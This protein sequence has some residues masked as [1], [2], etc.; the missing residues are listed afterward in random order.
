MTN[1]DSLDVYG[2]MAKNLDAFQDYLT[3]KKF[4]WRGWLYWENDQ[5]G[6]FYI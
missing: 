1:T 6:I 2:E 3:P 4:C 5:V